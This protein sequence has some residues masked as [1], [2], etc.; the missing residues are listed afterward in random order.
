MNENE[1]IVSEQPEVV[2]PV[3]EQPPKTY[4][5]EEVDAIVGK[6]LSRQEAKLR[7]E[8]ERTYGG[9][10]EVL[11]AGTGKETVEEVTDTFSQFYQQKGIQINKKP[12]YSEQDV[13][14][15]AKAEAEEII[16]AGYEEVV[17]EVERLTQVGFDNMTP[18]EKKVFKALAEHRQAAERGRELSKLGVTEDVYNSKE[19]T[20]FAGK[21]SPTTPIADV[22]DIYRKTQ[23]KKEIRTMGS[24]KS[25]GGTDANVKDFYTPEEARKFSPKYLDEHPEVE[26]A[27]K[28]SMPKWRK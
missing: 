5:Q 14:I 23:P 10:M 4:T 22:Y 18:R 6:R 9:L 20:D 26:A 12:T 11:R 21:F 2:E 16:R 15:L 8:T 13:A 3:T 19:F 17:D 24:M 1:Q 7:K 27:I 28:K 25:S